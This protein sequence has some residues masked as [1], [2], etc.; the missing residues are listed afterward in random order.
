VKMKSILAIALIPSFGSAASA[1]AYYMINLRNAGQKAT[2]MVNGYP[3]LTEGKTQDTSLSAPLNYWVV[4]GKNTVA[5]RLDRRDSTIGPSLDLKIIKQSAGAETTLLS[6]AYPAKAKDGSG[7]E[8]PTYPFDTTLAFSLSDPTPSGFWKEA[9]PLA[10]DAAT[11]AE[12]EALVSQLHEAFGKK[13]LK[14]IISLRDYP[15]RETAAVFGGTYDDMLKNFKDD[16]S[17]LI[18]APG[19]RPRP[20][21]KEELRFTLFAGDR[22]M[23]VTAEDG[24]DPLVF[25]VASGKS[26]IPVFIGKVGSKLIFIH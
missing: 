9:K 23:M 22:M 2:V 17:E 7:S 5:I 6:F 11:R 26:A 18:N 19:F 20:L 4:N 16:Y 8:K 10:L 1:Q 3:V 21:K 13:D 25:D 24:S 12:A 14:K 15:I